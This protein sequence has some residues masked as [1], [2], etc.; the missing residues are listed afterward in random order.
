MDYL[1]LNAIVKEVYKDLPCGC[2]FPAEFSRNLYTTVS[3]MD[4]LSNPDVPDVLSFFTLRAKGQASVIVFSKIQK[5]TNCASV[6]RFIQSVG[7]TWNGDLLFRN[8][9]DVL[10]VGFLTEEEVND[11]A[12]RGGS[13]A[14]PKDRYSNYEE[15][16]ITMSA[17]V[18]QAVLTT[19]LLRWLRFEAP[20]RVAVPRNVDYNSYVLSAMKQIY[21]L[22]PASLRGKAGF[23]SYLPNDKN[24][25]ESI[26]IGFVPEEMA[27]S[28]TLCLDGSSAA[29]CAKL[30]C[31]TNSTSLDAFI[32]QIANATEEERQEFF[33]EI[34]ADLEGSGSNEQMLLVSPRSYQTIGTALLLMNLHGSLSER[35]AQWNSKFFNYKE[36]DK[37]SACW[38]KRIRSKIRETID[39]AEF[40]QLAEKRLA[41]E[42]FDGLKAYEEYCI[43]NPELTDALWETVIVQQRGRKKSYTDIY[44]HVT[45]RQKELAFIL[46]T[47]KLDRLFCQSVEE[48]LL[49]LREKPAQSLKAINALMKEAQAL[50]EFSETRET[51]NAAQLQDGIQSYLDELRNRGNGM[52]LV[53]LTEGFSQIQTQP[54]RNDIQMIQAQMDE[55]AAYRKTVG[56][57]SHIPGVEQLLEE[58][59]AFTGTLNAR[60]NNLIHE[61]FAQRY[62]KIIS[63]PAK[64]VDQIEKVIASAAELLSEVAAAAQTQKNTELQATIQT[65]MEE[66]KKEI[67]SSNVKF[68]EIKKIL[69]NEALSYFAVLEALDKA[70]K[71]QLEEQH[72]QSIEDRLMLRSPGTPE[73]YEMA[74]MA[75]YSKPLT[76]ENVAALSDYVITVIVRDICR[77]DKITLKCSKNDS[78]AETAERI[79]RAMAIAGKISDRHTVKMSYDGAPVRDPEWFKNLLLMNHTAA[80]MGDKAH[81]EESVRRLV[82]KNTFSGNEMLS[83]LAMMIRCNL[84]PGIL[85]THVFQGDFRDATEQQYSQAYELLLNYAGDSGDPLQEMQQRANNEDL[86]KTA[87]KAFRSFVRSHKP[88]ETGTHKNKLMIPIICGLGA[89]IVALSVAVVLLSVK[90]RKTEVEVTVPTTVE[91]VPVETEPSVVLPE[92]FVFYYQNLEGVDLLYANGIDG[93]SNHSLRVA[94]L[95]DAMDEET[96]A[97]LLSTYSNFHGT[98]VDID[99]QGTAVS[100]DEY[101]FWVCWYYADQDIT[102]FR[103]MMQ[104]GEQVDPV[105]S[106][107]RVIHRDQPVM[108]VA[109]E[110]PTV[111]ETLPAEEVMETEAQTES[112]EEPVPAV[113]TVPEELNEEAE[114]AG[115]ETV[116]TEPAE[117]ESVVMTASDIKTAVTEA[118]A[119]SY[120]AAQTY[121]DKLVRIRSVFAEDF[122]QP[123]GFHAEQVAAMNLMGNEEIAAN[124]AFVQH[125]NTLPG[126]TVIYFQKNGTKVTWDEYVFWECW[127][128]AQRGTTVID[129]NTFNS[130]LQTEVDEILS[131]I[132]QLVSEDLYPV[133]V[134]NVFQWTYDGAYSADPVMQGIITHAGEAFAH[135]QAIYRYIFE[136]VSAQ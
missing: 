12:L 61:G 70:D 127:V 44:D 27:D 119:V 48:R 16:P 77:M 129:A 85:L 66:K 64:T 63:Y 136:Q 55:V 51:S 34:Y 60:K 92:E 59:D 15:I 54:Q 116:E 74:F 35:V 101:F 6:G 38:Q 33:E 49:V 91:T 115:T 17:Q 1:Y 58:M 25:P 78:A 47:G 21:S 18:K 93:F 26:F 110:T 131:V 42:A 31:G 124:E 32:A 130:E 100:W 62:S 4:C 14:L 2:P 118:A 20:L 98:T 45:K 95:L 81:L 24:V 123:F 90:I 117:T 52:V 19:V 132:H 37:I 108:A 99:D 103:D 134:E 71:S 107:L 69:D 135:A 8:L 113:D 89:L 79:A 96:E 53:K 121:M 46:D 109:E 29:V 84:D 13:F 104:S 125:Y 76:L 112:T 72:R 3:G 39:P 22:F 133:D 23:C 97:L 9:N 106:M 87:Q 65:F 40:C 80:T 11:S 50:K 105:L 86:D 5:H 10:N 120:E 7:W 88:S 67:Y 30:N 43:D 28:R 57:K 122:R 68:L 83:V 36:R 41:E 94:E 102:M 111:Q 128:L 73:D 114:T 126:D 82:E 75:C 56:E